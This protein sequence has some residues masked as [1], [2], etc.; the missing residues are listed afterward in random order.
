MARLKEFGERIHQIYGNNLAL[1]GKAATDTAAAF[2]GNANTY[3]QAAAPSSGNVTPPILTVEFTQPT[4]FDR[5]VTMERLN[6][7]QHITAYRIEVKERG[8]WREVAHAQAVGHKKI[9]I[10]PTVTATGLRLTL[11]DTNGP[12]QIREF[13]VYNGGIPY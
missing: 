10:F 12:A 2:D 11:L 3:W 4:T 7:G 8:E 9:D 6:D 13:Q 1:H 5:A